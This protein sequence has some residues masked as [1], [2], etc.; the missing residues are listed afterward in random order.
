MRRLQDRDPREHREPRRHFLE[1]GAAA[2]VMLGSP[3]LPGAEA[4]EG[5]AM[6]QNLAQAA[7]RRVIIDTDPG[8]DDALAIFLALSSPELKVEALTPVAGNVPL[9]LTLPNALRLLEIAGRTDIPVAAGASHPLVRTLITATYAHGENGLGGVVFPEPRTKPTGENASQLIRRMVRQSPGEISIVALGPLTNLALA[10]RADPELPRL[11]PRLVLMGGSLSGGNVSPAAEFNL[12]VDPE[13]AQIVFRSGVPLTMVGLDVTRRTAL[14]EEHIR[15]LEDSNNA[16]ARAAGKI[17]RATMNRIRQSGSNGG[18]NMHDSLA[19]ATF[20]DPSMVTLRD[21]F[22]EIETKGELTA[23]ETVGYTH[24]PVRRS[25]PMAD[26][27][28]MRDDAAKF[29]SNAKVAV[30]LDAE[31]FYKLLIGRLTGRAEA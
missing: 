26:G 13:A 29:E 21:Y 20:L 25:A 6:Q 5:L 28:A 16:V 27:P 8:I 3:W 22:I 31:R 30:D 2:C 19:L 4:A 10:F 7:K 15:A 23:G 14:R 18:P 9:E 11:I 24:A 17:T 1:R 12:Y